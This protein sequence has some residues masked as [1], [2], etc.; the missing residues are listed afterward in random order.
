MDVP[1]LVNQQRL[2]A[3]ALCGHKMQLRRSAW[4]DRWEQWI[5][6]YI[7][8]Y[9]ERERERK[10]ERESVCVCQGSPYCQWDLMVM[11]LGKLGSM[12]ILIFSDLTDVKGTLF[13]CSRRR[14][15]VVTKENNISLT[16]FGTY[17]KTLNGQTSIK[18]ADIIV[19]K[20]RDVPIHFLTN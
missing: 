18:H 2:L 13:N 3:S 6:I 12:T 4:S 9:K 15:S 14:Y 1:V 19:C 17:P 8:I 7:Y 10:R 16:Q 20:S 5:Y 11:I